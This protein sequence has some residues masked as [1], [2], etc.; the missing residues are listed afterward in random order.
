[1][2]S[3][4][5]SRKV[6]VVIVSLVVAGLAW[7]GLSSGSPATSLLDTQAVADHKIDQDLVDTLLALRSVKLDGVILTEPAFKGLKDFSTQI[8]AEPIGRPNPFAPLSGAVTA[9][10]TTKGAQIFSAPTKPKG[11]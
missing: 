11:K 8:I 2:L 4:L 7:Y 10:S 3:F 1:M 5:T 9:A 6:I